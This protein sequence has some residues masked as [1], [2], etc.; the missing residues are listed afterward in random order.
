MALVHPTKKNPVGADL[1][2][3]L[4]QVKV[5]DDSST[6][7][8]Y[9]VDASIYRMTPQVVVLPDS[10]ADIE[11]VME[12]AVQ[13]GIPLTTRAA[14]T[15]LTGSAVGSGIILDV[16]HLNRILELNQEEQ[17]A[18]IQPGIILN[19]LNKQL[20]STGLMFGPDP[21]SGDM[22]KLGGMLAN[23]SSGPHTLRYG[24][25]KDN[26]LS[27]R[28]CLESGGWLNAGVEQ[29][30]SRQCRQ[31]F[32]QFAALETIVNLVR[33]H[34][35][36]IHSK[37][38][39]VSKNSAGYNLFDVAAG[40][41]RG[42]VD[43]P[44][45]F[46]GSEGTLGVF[47]EATIQ[48][49]DRP[50]ATVTGMIHFQHLEEMGESVHHLLKLDPLA[51]EVMDGNTLNMIGRS[52]HHIPEDA[53]ATLLIEFDQDG[54][55]G[56]IAQLKEACQKYRLAS[57]PVI[58]T[59]PE[60]Q[61]NLWKARKALYPTLYRYDAKKKPINYV[62][63]VVVASDRI[64]E[65]I[66][67]LDGTFGKAKVPLAIFGHIGNGNAHIV[68][69]LDVNDESDFQRMVDTYYEV[70]Q[71][72]LDQFG[73][74]ICGEHGDGR[75]RAEMVKRMFG[76]ELYGLFVQVKQTLDPAGVLN[77][78]VKI[79]ETSFT[80]NID[81]ER[82]GKACATCAKCNSVCPV[83][84]VFQSEDM[85]SRGWFEIVTDPNYSYLDSKRVVEAC[86]NCKSCRTIC[87]ADVDVSELILQRRAEHP[88]KLAGKIFGLHAQSA[89]FEKLIKLAA[90]TQSLWDRPLVRR[91]LDTVT[92]PLL[93]QL[94]ENARFPWDMKLPRLAKTLLRERHQEL[95]LLPNPLPLQE[96]KKVAYFH[97]CAA[98]YFDD[99]VGDAVIQVMKRYGVT[100]DLPPQRC[101]GTPIETYGHRALAKEG[102]RENLKNFDGYETVVTGCASCTLALKDYEKWFKG[103]PE[104]KTAARLAKRVK[105]ISEFALERESAQPSQKKNQDAKKVTYHSSCHLRAAGV[106]K[107]PRQL[108]ANLPGVDYVEMQDADRCAG[109]AGTY[110]VK[111]Y[112]TSQKIFQ[113]KKAAIQNSQ[114]EVV[115]TSCPACMIQLKNGLPEKTSVKHIAQVL[116]ENMEDEKADSA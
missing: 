59:D 113:R 34:R 2:R 27:M 39:R 40:I 70:H 28:V 82:L 110:I 115:A 111:D 69:L 98:N 65:L 5:K 29:L 25:V 24:S 106:T 112:E 19:E 109:G 56:G 18:R 80:E 95:C 87:P 21:S 10:E 91:I 55:H 51:L 45:L 17:W 4:G 58:A 78:G 41:D 15:N 96:E 48:L 1:R 93:K 13:K 84:D 3:L 8:A 97:G 47:S 23:N 89:K 79:S 61:Q 105:H 72:V 53:A 107:Q 75:I 76:E 38:P 7:R 44:K 50:R 66:R 31:T 77:P 90:R 99:G 52:Q 6:L 104:E 100:P 68:P 49:V 36:L 67:Y 22:C 74:S 85:S 94:A 101:S 33:D 102:A 62:D 60:Q 83:Y 32:D 81:F 103:E 114:A 57:D 20:A 54:D 116:L 35:E 73:G 108:L 46:V 71:T 92:R 16:S 86:L 64:G 14:G 43:F 42:I 37:R 11:R 12:Y 9:A 30:D 26:V 88:N 63:D